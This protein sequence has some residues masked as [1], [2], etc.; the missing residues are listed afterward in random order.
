MIFSYLSFD[1]YLITTVSGKHV[2]NYV[3]KE[4]IV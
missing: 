4:L 1:F 2:E 3:S